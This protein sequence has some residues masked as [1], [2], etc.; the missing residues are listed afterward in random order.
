LDTAGISARY[1][2]FRSLSEVNGNPWTTV[3]EFHAQGCIP[4]QPSSVTESM[5]A[6]SIYPNPTSGMVTIPISGANIQHI[7]FTD[8]R[9]RVIRT[10]AGQFDQN[11]IMLDC[12]GIGTGFYQIRLKG[13][14]GSMYRCSIIIQ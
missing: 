8:A 2:K 11:D 9:G 10:F 4:P 1:V 13:I 7:E 12:S 6:L 14:N 3:A 5:E